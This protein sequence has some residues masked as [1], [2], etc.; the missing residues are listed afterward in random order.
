LKAEVC[1]RVK[2]KSGTA[3]PSIIN[4]RLCLRQWWTWFHITTGW[5]MWSFILPLFRRVRKISKSHY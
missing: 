1:V 4:V 5:R 3:N 2:K